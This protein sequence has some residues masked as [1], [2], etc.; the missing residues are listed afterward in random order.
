MRK[1]WWS[2]GEDILTCKERT[3]NVGV[4]FGANVS[5]PALLQKLVGEFLFCA[6]G[7]L[8]GKFAG[9]WRDFL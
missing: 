6:Q 3:R 2:W 8:V 4:N 9:I 1:V 7:K 5:L